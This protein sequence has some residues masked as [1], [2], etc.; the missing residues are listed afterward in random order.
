MILCIGEI[1]MDET[2]SATKTV[3]HL[4]GAP[5][6]LAANL[7]LAGERAGFAW[8][9]G[10]DDAGSFLRKRAA[11]IPFTY[12]SLAPSDAPTMRSLVTIANGGERSFV[13]PESEVFPREMNRF[14]LKPFYALSIVHLGSLFLADDEGMAFG[15]RIVREARA[16]GARVSFDV[17]YRAGI[18]ATEEKARLKLGEFA[19]EADI[20][21]MSRD[22]AFFL[23]GPSYASVL[24]ELGSTRLVFETAGSE[25]SALHAKGLVTQAAA[26]LV[27]ANDA[28]G[29]G[30]AYFASVLSSLSR[31]PA[32]HAFTEEERLELLTKANDAGARATLFRG[33]L[34]KS[35]S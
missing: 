27:K 13:F 34:P 18:F 8:A 25:G 3:R 19:R 26:R 14:S 16:A 2:R 7:A 15:K 5:F 17:N 29:A 35:R 21:K 31:L 10:D 23:Y 24:D 28:T 9:L 22:D 32:A 1:V 20:L 6:N 12:L 4:G 11:F 30:D 33:A